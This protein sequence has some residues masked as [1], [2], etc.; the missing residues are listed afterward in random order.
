[1]E[2]TKVEKRTKEQNAII[3]IKSL[4]DLLSQKKE[5]ENDIQKASRLTA[6]SISDYLKTVC[7]L[8]GVELNEPLPFGIPS[9]MT[10]DTQEAYNNLTIKK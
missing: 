10:N 8:Y 9:L 5:D 4:I 3:S 1:M 2:N 6:Q 7:E